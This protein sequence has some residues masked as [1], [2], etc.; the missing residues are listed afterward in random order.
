MFRYIIS[1]Y[2]GIKYLVYSAPIIYMLS[3]VLGPIGVTCYVGSVLIS[4]I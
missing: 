2:R 3:P 1:L 4:M